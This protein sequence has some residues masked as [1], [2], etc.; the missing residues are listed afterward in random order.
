MDEREKI[1]FQKLELNNFIQVCERIFVFYNSDEFKFF[2]SI[3]FL[4]YNFEDFIKYGY[5]QYQKY[6]IKN[7][8]EKIM[9]IIF[10]QFLKFKKLSRI[11]R[12]NKI[13]ID[14][15][16]FFFVFGEVVLFIFFCL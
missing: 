9:N 3:M 7:K 1:C 12:I 14:K 6:G 15:L 13:G 16:S 2:Y 11:K 10:F 8:I 4:C 5:E